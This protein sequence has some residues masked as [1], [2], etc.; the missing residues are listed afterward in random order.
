MGIGG[1]EAPRAATAILAGNESWDIGYRAKPLSVA[2][3]VFLTR[4]SFYSRLLAAH[5]SA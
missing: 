1:E 2:G 4:D 5:W 3:E